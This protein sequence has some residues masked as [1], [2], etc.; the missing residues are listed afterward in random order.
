MTFIRCHF[1][2]FDVM[3][4]RRLLRDADVF[5]RLRRF[6]HATL[7]PLPLLASALRYVTLRRFTR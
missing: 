3:R 5:R 6:S 2:A 7:M 4:A 1:D